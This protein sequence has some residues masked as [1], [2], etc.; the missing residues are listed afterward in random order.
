MKSEQ[1]ERIKNWLGTGSI[2]VFGRPFAGKDTQCTRL[3]DSLDGMVIAGGD[4]LRSH[5]DKE[6]VKKL[7]LTGKLF[8]PDYYISIVLPFLSK[9]EFAKKPLILSS[10][11]RWYGEEKNVIK[12]S[13]SSGHPLCAVIYLVVS[14]EEI[15]RRWNIKHVRKDRGDRHDD[16]TEIQNTRQDEF[17][18]KTLPVLDFYRSKGLLIEVDGNAS[19][20][21]VATKILTALAKYI[22][23]S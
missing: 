7:M 15:Q 6:T 13:K 11:G 17:K 1:I 10:V 12:A 20:D 3:A 23:S 9:P 8:P 19:E 22:Q 16:R 2:N 5:P 14:D 21:E 18:N 4:I